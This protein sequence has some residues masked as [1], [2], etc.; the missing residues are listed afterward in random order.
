MKQRDI[1]FL[2]ISVFALIAFWI[3]FNIF[4]NLA[5]TTISEPIEKNII[6]ISPSFDVKTINV[7][8]NRQNVAPLYET[9]ISSSSSFQDITKVPLETF[10][11]SPSASEV[12]Q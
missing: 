3:G 11:S 9:E 8:K 10:E 6:P 12:S 5:V 7:I 4:H 1:L 2:S